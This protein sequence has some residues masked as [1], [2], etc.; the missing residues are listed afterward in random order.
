MSMSTHEITTLAELEVFAEVFV[1]NI[2]AQ[3]GG[4]TVVGLVGDLGAGKTTFVQL[5][6]KYLGV[7]ESVTSPT[8][9]IMREYETTH[10]VFKQL[11]HMDAYRIEDGGELGPLRFAEVLARPGTLV[12][13]EWVERIKDALPPGYTTL[14]FTVQPDTTRTI[15]ST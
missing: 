10:P 12:C 5:L 14:S 8:Y 15:A 7:V 4:A 1:K 3:S 9:L 13:I 6:A 11:V 2:T